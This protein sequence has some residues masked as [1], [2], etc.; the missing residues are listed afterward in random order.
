[1]ASTPRAPTGSPSD[2]PSVSSRF[3]P[4]TYV[5]G[6]RLVMPV[7]FPDGSTAELVYPPDLGLEEFSIQPY[8]SGYGP[9]FGRDFL[10]IHGSV[11]EVVGRY[12]EAH[13]LAEYEDGQG[14][15]SGSGVY[16]RTASI[17][18]SSSGPGR[19]SSMTTPGTQ[20]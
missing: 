1:V 15:Q 4:Q 11:G 12:R 18:P 9:G 8:S 2:S 5:E 10:V 20:R 17:S 13:L 6:Q 14:K 19:C 3:V 16:R 7:T